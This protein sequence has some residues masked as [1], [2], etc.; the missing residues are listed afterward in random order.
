MANSTY[1]LMQ[2]QKFKDQGYLL[3]IQGL[4]QQ[5][6]DLMTAAKQNV[7]LIQ[8]NTAATLEQTAREFASMSASQRA[9]AGASGLDVYSTSF[10]NVYAATADIYTRDINRLQ[11]V[12]RQQQ[13]NVLD[14]AL[15]QA[16][17]LKV[18]IA[19]IQVQQQADQISNLYQA[20]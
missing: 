8:S 3:Q 14:S 19:S 13:Q 18:G 2:A 20:L 6:N 12:T 7:Q 1:Q 10:M 16:E 5:S 15:R 17:A 11:T 4:N 9:S